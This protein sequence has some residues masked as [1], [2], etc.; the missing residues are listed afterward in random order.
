[1]A[2]TSWRPSCNR[3]TGKTIVGAALYTLLNGL[4]ARMMFHA[5]SN[6]A[7]SGLT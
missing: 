7:S 1:M 5:R 4:G 6:A 3:T 2:Q